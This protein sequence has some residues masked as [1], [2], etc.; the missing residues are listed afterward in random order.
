MLDPEECERARVTRD[1]RFDGVFFR[2]VRTIK[3]YCRPVCPVRPAQ[4]KNV[5]FYPSAAAVEAAGFRPCLQFPT[6]SGAVFTCVERLT[7]YSGTSHA[8]NQ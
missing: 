3:I 4:A 8:P 7:D 1:P 6:G 2:S 5:C